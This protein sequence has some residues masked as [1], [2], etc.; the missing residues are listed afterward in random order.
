M[1]QIIYESRL[2]CASR[3]ITVTSVVNLG[4]RCRWHVFEQNQRFL[5][6]RYSQTPP[7][8]EFHHRSRSGLRQFL[9]LTT[10]PY[11]R[12]LFTLKFEALWSVV[13]TCNST[14]VIWNSPIAWSIGRE[15]FIIIFPPL[16]PNPMRYVQWMLDA[17][18][19]AVRYGR[20]F[21]LRHRASHLKH[22][23]YRLWAIPHLVTAMGK[24]GNVR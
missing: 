5:S 2:I 20:S 19:L 15:V 24:Q 8:A 4:L 3:S 18:R 12:I 13:S 17:L 1:D 10:G 22:M 21:C 7:T 6:T 9:Q 23:R 11:F 14:S 16:R